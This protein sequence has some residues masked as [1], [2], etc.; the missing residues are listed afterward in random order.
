MNLRRRVEEPFQ[1]RVD[2]LF[3]FGELRIEL[4]TERLRV[5]PQP[6]V[7]V[8]TVALPGGKLFEVAAEFREFQLFAADVDL[9]VGLGL[10]F[11]LLAV[12]LFQ[13]LLALRAA[14]PLAEDWPAERVRRLFFWYNMR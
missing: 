4:E 3:L 6:R 7:L 12:F 5:A 10:V 1:R 14:L 2:L 9:V 8:V 11:F 13:L